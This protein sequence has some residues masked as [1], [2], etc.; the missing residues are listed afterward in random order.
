MHRLLGETLPDVSV[1]FHWA[2]NIKGEGEIA[3]FALD[4]DSAPSRRFNYRYGPPAV[5][6]RGGSARRADRG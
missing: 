1:D 2:D 4:G 5:G 6:S 3:E